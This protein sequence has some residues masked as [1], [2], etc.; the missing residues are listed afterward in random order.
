MIYYRSIRNSK[1]RL[2]KYMLLEMKAISQVGFLER[3]D[4]VGGES[5]AV[6]HNIL[7]HK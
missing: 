2:K 1:K 5:Y 4:T 6:N 7:R 3:R